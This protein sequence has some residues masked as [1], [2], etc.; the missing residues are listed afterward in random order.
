MSNIH[1]GFRLSKAEAVYMQFFDA[2]RCFLPKHAHDMDITFVLICCFN[3]FYTGYYY[4][5]ISIHYLV[6]IL[7][8]HIWVF[9]PHCLFLA[10]W[11]KFC[12]LCCGL[13]W[14]PLGISVGTI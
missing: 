10:S 4:I 2:V 14:P 9:R 5:D 12:S 13:Q 8:I 1:T 3:L 11:H 7:C 6:C